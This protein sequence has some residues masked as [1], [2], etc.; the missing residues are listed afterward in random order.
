MKTEITAQWTSIIQSKVG[1]FDIDLKGLWRYRDLIFLF[2]RR[3]FVSVYKQTILGP[4][5]FVLQ[6]LFTTIVFTVV[7]GNI[8]Q[9]STDG[10]PKILFYFSGTVTWT[11]FSNCLN[12]TSSTFISNAGIFGKVYF[13]RLSVPIS[14]VISKVITF[15]LQFL[16]FLCF[17]AYYMSAGANVQPNMAIFLTPALLL[18]MASLGLGFGIIISSLT[19]KYRDLKFLVGFGTSLFMY[20]TPVVYPL[21][22]VPEKYKVLI[23]ANP[24]TPVVE[25][26][27]YAYL[28]QGTF[29][30]HHLGLSA[31][32]TLVFLFIGL[33]LFSKVEKT[34]MDTV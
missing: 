7:F 12:G 29:N 21:S 2:V 31:F 6:P 11:Y 28:G 5:W 17:M 3:D 13:P 34:F 9:I 10:L 15:G 16:F 27:R 14:I 24:M 32:T 25:T 20:A 30:W 26:F 18:L 22:T 23:L 19:T 4:L 33:M 1:W 8:A